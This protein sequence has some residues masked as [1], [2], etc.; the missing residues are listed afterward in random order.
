MINKMQKEYLEKRLSTIRNEKINNYK[1]KNPTVCFG[2]ILYNEIKNGGV[3]LKNK[4]ECERYFNYSDPDISTFFDVSKAR[5][6]YNNQKTKDYENKINN[7]CLQIMD[8]VMFEGLDLDSAIKE[9][10]NI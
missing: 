10:E 1:E 6:I 4:N 2:E 9:I 7:K 3:F 5:D 8:K